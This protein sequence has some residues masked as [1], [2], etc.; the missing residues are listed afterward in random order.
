MSVF[1]V[2]A[3]TAGHALIDRELYLPGSWTD[4]RD[5]CAAAGV[6]AGTAFAT[7][8]VLARRMIGR[9]VGGGVP[10]RWATADEAYGKDGALRAA[11][12]QRNLG[13]VL[14][15]AC[16]HRIPI[17][18][19]STMRV[20]TAA[21]VLPTLVWQRLSAGAG[22]KGQRWY[23]W[24]WVRLHTSDQDGH[25]VAVGPPSSQDRGPG[26][27]PVLLTDRG[28][29]AGIGAGGGTP[30]EYRGSLSDQQTAGRAGSGPDVDVV[31]SLDDSRDARP[32]VP[33]RRDRSYPRHH[34]NL[35]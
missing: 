33:C 30:V 20:D 9:A 18:G 7:K 22:V 13:Y 6:P 12:E 19:G 11:L 26:V 31:V 1:L 15:V 3:S 28:G 5:R 16:D 21:R 34:R 10:V 4:D 29:A 23:D 27:L 35:G 24:A 14:A 25:R 8:T 2:Y 17:L 32:C